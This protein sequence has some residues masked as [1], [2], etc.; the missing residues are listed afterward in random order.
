MYFP[1]FI[2][3]YNT[4]RYEQVNIFLLFNFPVFITLLLSLRCLCISTTYCHT[5]P[6]EKY[7]CCLLCCKLKTCPE[8][9]YKTNVRDICEGPE[10]REGFISDPA[11]GLSHSK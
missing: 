8:K 3:C 5:G 7:V 1:S 6:Q 11:F 10:V 4:G 2:A 9:I